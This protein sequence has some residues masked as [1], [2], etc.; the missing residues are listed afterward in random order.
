MQK[1]RKISNSKRKQIILYPIFAQEDTLLKQQ[2][3][4]YCVICGLNT[5]S[6]FT[7]NVKST[8][9]ISPVFHLGLRI[10]CTYKFH[11]CASNNNVFLSQQLY[12]ISWWKTIVIYRHPGNYIYF[13]ISDFV[14]KEIRIYTHDGD[15]CCIQFTYN[16][17][18]HF[19]AKFQ[20]KGLPYRSEYI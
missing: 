8:Q 3:N 1:R 13:G 12:C 10:I 5:V 9:Q 2:L 19:S 16:I 14:G 11:A 17:L 7:Y 18:S 20:D 15:V 6:S 4:A